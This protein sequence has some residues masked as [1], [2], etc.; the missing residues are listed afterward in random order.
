MS[1]R[2]SEVVFAIIIVILVLTLIVGVNTSLVFYFWNL[3]LVPVFNIVK[4]TWLQALIGGLFLGLFIKNPE[5][6][7]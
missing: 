7:R 4:I 1:Y 6:K 5:I 3:V 2:F